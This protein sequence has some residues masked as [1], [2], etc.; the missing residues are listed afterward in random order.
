MKTVEIKCDT[1]E[2]DL[3]YKSNMVDYRLVLGSEEKPGDGHGGAYTAM[4]IYPPVDRTHHFCGLVCLAKW[5]EPQMDYLLKRYEHQQN[6]R[7]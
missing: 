3:T 4:M 6:H 7:K 5:L 1:C 2:S